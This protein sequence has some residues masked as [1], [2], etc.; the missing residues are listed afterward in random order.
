[1]AEK[2]STDKES[3]NKKPPRRKRLRFI[4]VFI[5]IALIQTLVTVSCFY[6]FNRNLEK[7]N[8]EHLDKDS[9]KENAEEQEFE[10]QDEIKEGEDIVGA[11]FPIETF[12]VNLSDSGYI[13]LEIQILLEQREVPRVLYLKT[14]ILRDLIISLLSQKTRNQMLSQEGKSVLKQEIS[15]IIDTVLKQKKTK[16][17]L[18]GQFVVQ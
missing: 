7:N 3:E 2:D 1:M 9:A 4:I 18:F 10:E 5:L 11:I 17:I 12:L 6:Y 8:L 15:T 14:P 16:Q 13:R